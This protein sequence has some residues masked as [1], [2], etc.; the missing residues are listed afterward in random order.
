MKKTKWLYWNKNPKRKVKR[1]QLA[2]AIILGK[3]SKRRKS[4]IDADP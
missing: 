4:E 3:K 1:G 2:E